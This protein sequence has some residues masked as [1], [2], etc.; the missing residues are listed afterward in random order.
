MREAM[1][2]SELS[3]AAQPGTQLDA[4]SFLDTLGLDNSTAKYCYG[5]HSRSSVLEGLPFGGVPTVL[6]I[7]V[8]MWLVS[9]QH[10]CQPPTS[11]PGETPSCL[12]QSLTPPSCI[13]IS[14]VF[15]H[16]LLSLSL[17]TSLSLFPH[18]S[19]RALSLEA[20]L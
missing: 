2:G 10:G 9:T 6:A 14:S 16:Q 8:V 12:S 5:A 11:T 19:Q 13:G 3:M 7:N 15:P 17:S 18:Q 1:A 4:P 20:S